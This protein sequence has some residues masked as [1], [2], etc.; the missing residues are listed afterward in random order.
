METGADNLNGS[1]F[2]QALRAKRHT[3]DMS[4]QYKYVIDKLSRDTIEYYPAFTCTKILNPVNTEFCLVATDSVTAIMNNRCD[5]MAVLNFA[6]FKNPGG[7]FLNGSIAQEECLCHE[8]MLYNV[9][10]TKTDYY[11]RNLEDL[12]GSLYR[13]RALFTPDVV[14]KREDDE[15]LCGVIT[16]AAPN[17]RA[18]NYKGSTNAQNSFALESRMRFI[19]DIAKDNNVST[20]ILGA[21]GCGVFGQNGDEVA[22]LFHSILMEPLYTCFDKIIFAVPDERSSNYKA[23]AKEFNL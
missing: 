9:L 19:F 20:L 12:A 22:H 8:S 21:Y 10:A 23:F 11:K 3:Q 13:N 7:G 15:V 5:R 2:V 18:A 17:K 1:K 6:S 4:I 14:F 16:C